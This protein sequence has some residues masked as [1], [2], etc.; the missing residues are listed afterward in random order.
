ME[1]SNAN[2]SK[3][4]PLCTFAKCWGFGVMVFPLAYFGPYAI[5]LMVTHLKCGV[6]AAAFL[7]GPV[8]VGS[9]AFRELC[10]GGFGNS[11]EG[12]ISSSLKLLQ[13]LHKPLYPSLSP[14]RWAYEKMLGY[15]GIW[16]GI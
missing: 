11:A 13:P 6:P 2:E 5:K 4:L 10:G 9:S 15:V 14:Q 1:A 7:T 16:K 3:E 12:I 8:G